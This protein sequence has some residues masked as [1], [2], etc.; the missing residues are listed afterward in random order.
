MRKLSFFS[1]T[2]F[3]FT[4]MKNRCILNGHVFVMF[5]NC[6]RGGNSFLLSLSVNSV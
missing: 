2:F 5:A 6:Q 4:A 3:I 1:I